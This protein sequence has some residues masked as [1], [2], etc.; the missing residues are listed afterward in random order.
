MFDLAL[1]G[2]EGKASRKT[3]EAEAKGSISQGRQAAQLPEEHQSQPRTFFPL[4]N[5]RFII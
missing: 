1:Q 3:E 2:W 4:Q 5:F